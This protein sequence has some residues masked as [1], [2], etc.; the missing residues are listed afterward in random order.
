VRSNP[1]CHFPFRQGYVE[2]NLEL[3]AKWVHR[4]KCVRYYGGDVD[5]HWFSDTK[6]LKRFAI[7]GLRV[8]GAALMAVT[9]LGPIQAPASV[10]AKDLEWSDVR[11][12]LTDDADTTDTDGFRHLPDFGGVRHALAVAPNGDIFAAGAGTD[13]DSDLDGTC[14]SLVDATQL[15]A[16]GGACLTAATVTPAIFKSTDG[17]MKWRSAPVWGAGTLAGATVGLGTSIQK[18]AV[19]PKYPTDNF[20]MVVFSLAA[21]GANTN[22]VAF[23]TDGGANFSSA[24]TTGALAANVFS[25]V[26]LKSIALSPDF[27]WADGNG[28]IAFGGTSATAN[29]LTQAS[30]S[31]WKAATAA[32]RGTTGGAGALTPVTMTADDFNTAT[33]A[34]IDVSYTNNEEPI[35]LAALYLDFGY[36]TCAA[37]VTANTLPDCAAG[38]ASIVAGAVATLGKVAFD[39]TYT[40]GGIFFAAFTDA[41]SV[42]GAFRFTGS[43]WERKTPLAGSDCGGGVSDLAISGNGSTTRMVAGL[44]GSNQVCR[45]TNEGGSWSKADADGGDSVCDN[46]KMTTAG[47]Q[48]TVAANRV[49]PN[50]VYWATSTVSTATRAGGGVA[51]STDTGSSWSDTG[52]INEPAN[53]NTNP[54]SVN[55]QVVFAN[56]RMNTSSSCTGS[57]TCNRHLFLTENFGTGAAWKRVFRY[58]G[59]DASLAPVPASFT[60]DNTLYMRRTNA[61]TENLLKSSDGGRTWKKTTA[62]PLGNSP[63]ANE[64]LSA[65]S[66]RSG[67]VIFIGGSKGHVSS[68]TDGGSSWTLLAKDFG[69]GLDEFDFVDTAR[70]MFI[71][72]AQDTDN[73]RKLWWTGDSGA[74][75]TQI[76]DATMGWGTGNPATVPFATLIDGLDKK[77]GKG[78]VLVV[79]ANSGTGTI[80]NTDLY[81]YD[82]AAATA[83][84]VDGGTDQ[85]WTENTTIATPG[86]GDGFTL[87]LWRTGELVRT[88]TPLNTNSTDWT[89]QRQKM[90]TERP[91]NAAGFT[92]CR[93]A[94]GAP[95]LLVANGGR[96]MVLTLPK[97]FQSGP[98]ITSPVNNSNVPSNVGNDGVPTV[99]RWNSVSKANCYELQVSLEN[100][101]NSPTL[102]GADQAFGAATCG[103]VANNAVSSGSSY[104]ITNTVIALVTGQQY[105]WRVR[106]RASDA[107]ADNAA[108]NQASA[109]PWSGV[110]T[111][112]V[113][114]TSPT[115]NVPQPSLPLNNSQLPGLSTSLSWNNPAGVTQVQIQV[116]PMNGDGPAIN[117]IFGSAIS[118]YDVPAP[119][120]GT[121]PYVMLPGATY[122][123]R[124]RTTNNT[125]AVGEFDPSWG[126]WSEPRSFTTAK[127][128]SGT[129]QL[130][131][132]INGKVVTSTTPSVTWKDANAAMF[133]YEVQLSSDPNFGEQG[134]KAPV[135]YNLIHGGQSTPPDS[136]KVPDANALPKGTYSWRV[137]QRVQATLAGTSETGIP[138]TPSQSFVVQ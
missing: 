47:A 7:K 94:D 91:A 44:L 53:V 107:S 58:G 23:S 63:D 132:P 48:P 21:A 12:P 22:G 81:T 13:V 83:T 50:V 122:T 26:I 65:D 102:N 60:T 77:T 10:K 45:T 129:I 106:V 105:W 92:T 17:G 57:G 87:V 46:C 18:I 16:G 72:T 8:A 5:T 89:N 41:G 33:D 78:K 84:W 52:I 36:G 137:R 98:A 69:D 74:T 131:D 14:T 29:N 19:S 75:F 111:F 130:V 120:F 38:T 55:D 2:G 34:I 61:T 96:Y 20:V 4:L 118:G 126:P 112:T 51:R 100:N 54:R 79:A 71:V 64:L 86:V 70:T 128:N 76:G 134:A 6:G 116:T 133:Y 124:L 97:D 135:F 42:G 25:T 80:S 95:C 49:T 35:T 39:D 37:V 27:S 108:G 113:S 73:L 9:L 138:W 68:S 115:V 3:F 66:T 31:V 43:I 40:S 62:D 125:A 30:T 1:V 85:N 127:P 99:F 119:L 104:Q 93:N 59:G 121:G 82:L 136:W 110:N 101:F 32:N 117:L 11:P 90:Q 24:A 88:A 67:S 109:S 28:S 56:A 103:V 123:W 114:T 15:P